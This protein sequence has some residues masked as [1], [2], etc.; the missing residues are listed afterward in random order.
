VAAADTLDRAIVAPRTVR[1]RDHQRHLTRAGYRFAAPAGVLVLLCVLLPLVV[2][3]VLSLT[4]YRLVAVDIA[5]IGLDNY[6]DVLSEP[7]PRQALVN[8]LIYV[9]IVVPGAVILGL[10]IA[11]L[12]QRRRHSRRYYEIVFFL[13]V[14]STMAAMAVVWQYMLHGRIG[15]IN[16]VLSALGFARVDFLTDPDVALFTLAGIGVW[17]LVG[18]TMVLFLAGLTA[19]PR[20]LYEAAALDGADTGFDRFWRVTWPLLAPTTLFVVITTSITAFQVFDTV[21]VLT[22]GG[23]MQSTEVL[24]YK[25]YEEGFA[26]FEIGRAAALITIF[27]VFILGFSLLQFALA[28]RRIHYGLQP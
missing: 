16:A 10:V 21:A 13:P 24:L 1:Q 17:Q 7:A 2:V 26:Y 19:I 8:T 15:P 12:V 20:D 11:L 14:T 5:F 28:E 23:P 18:F 6:R 9:A 22:K 4:D 3:L 25:V 27:L